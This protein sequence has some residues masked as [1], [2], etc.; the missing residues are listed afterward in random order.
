MGYDLHIT[1]AKNWSD[2]K[3]KWISSEE[4]LLFV[5][6]DSELTLNADNGPFFTN[7]SGQ[8]SYEYPW[9]DWSEGNVFTKNPDKAI[10]EKMLYIANKLNAKVQGEDGEVYNSSNNFP[11]QI[12]REMSTDSQD[13]P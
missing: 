5:K 9:L 2:N 11:D 3:N 1:R 6:S 8:S 13:P 4:W 7:W 12:A 10:V